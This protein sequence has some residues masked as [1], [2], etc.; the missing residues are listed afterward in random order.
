MKQLL[1][2]VLF[3]ALLFTACGGDEKTA[4]EYRDESVKAYCDKVFDCFPADATLQY[5]SE[6]QCVTD[7]T[8]GSVTCDDINYEHA[9]DCLAC[10][11]NLS[12][13]AIGSGTDT[14]ASSPACL[15][16]CDD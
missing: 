4:N 2:L 3:G 16:A 7:G 1:F 9:D 12:C 5:G 6:S 14:C 11:K 10:Y 8:A 13:T 15:H